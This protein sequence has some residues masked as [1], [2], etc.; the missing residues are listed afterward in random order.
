MTFVLIII[1]TVY[2]GGAVVTQHDYDNEKACEAAK[3]FVV[4][5]LKDMRESHVTCLPR[6]VVP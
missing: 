1:T 3:A 6:S 5:S 2:V 4:E